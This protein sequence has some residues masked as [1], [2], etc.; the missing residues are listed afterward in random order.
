LLLQHHYREG[1]EWSPAAMDQA[2]S[3]AQRLAAAAREPD[4]SSSTAREAFAAALSD[5]LDTPAALRVLEGAS[6]STLLELATVLGLG[7]T[8]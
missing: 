2:A 1:W 8:D 3:L 6:G 4:V 5:D 7:L